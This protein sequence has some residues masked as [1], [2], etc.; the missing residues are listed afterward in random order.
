MAAQAQQLL[1]AAG[2][3]LDEKGFNHWKFEANALSRDWEVV[4][5]KYVQEAGG[6]GPR[7]V[8][9]APDWTCVKNWAMIA[10]LP[11]VFGVKAIKHIGDGIKTF[12]QTRDLKQ[13]QKIGMHAT[14]LTGIALAA[15]YLDP[16][17]Y[18]LGVFGY[19][20]IRTALF[21]YAAFNP[22]GCQVYMAEAES[23]MNAKRDE[24]KTDG[25]LVQ[26]SV[27]ETLAALVD[28]SYSFAHLFK[29]VSNPGRPSTA[30]SAAAPDVSESGR[31]DSASAD[32]KKEA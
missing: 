13:V 21:A 29:Q 9:D 18:G 4:D 25:Q 12:H 5:E 24:S 1:A 14:M 11:A 30:E 7:Y 8:H 23:F 15:H 10:C 2:K 31:D 27:K 20:T 17:V 26:M 28:G 16:Q 32:D 22:F 19:G 3:F 6:K